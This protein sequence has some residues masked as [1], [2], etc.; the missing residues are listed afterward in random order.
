MSQILDVVEPYITGPRGPAGT[1]TSAT[2]AA[3]PPGSDPTV[4]MSGSD[5]DRAVAFGIP[6]GEKGDPGDKGDPGNGSVNS[7]NGNMGPDVVL[8]AAD[9]GGSTQATQGTMPIRGAGGRL[10]GI[11]APTASTEAANK[12][13]VDA[14]VSALSVTERES[15][16]MPD[17]RF[18]VTLD[19]GFVAGP[20]GT[21]LK[22]P[23][24][25]TPSGGET[26]HPAVVYFPDGWNGYRY[27][28]AHTPYP[29]GNDAHED[30]NICASHD[31]DTWVVPAGLVNPL[32][33]APGTPRYNS[34]TELVY[35]DGKLWCFWRYQD[36][37]A[38]AAS[39]NIY[40]R[41]STNG[42]TWTAKQLVQQSNKDTKML[43]SPTL[44]FEG[45]RWT[46]WAVDAAQP[47]NKL[48]RYR[49]TGKSPLLGQWGAEEACSLTA[50][51]GRDIW[52]IQVKRVGD[53]L[54]ALLNDC[55]AGQNGA[56]GDLYLVDSIDGLKWSAPTRQVIPR[57]K[58]GEHT[59]LYRS[60]FVPGFLDGNFGLHV[61]Y[62]GWV[63][64]SPNVWN[65]FRTFVSADSGWIPL[66]VSR[67]WQGLS[68]H[69]PR[70]R[71][72]NGMLIVEGAVSRVST[73]ADFGSLATL[74]SSL[75]RRGTKTTF[76]G[77][78]IAK[79]GA[80]IGMAEVYVA[81]DTGLVRCADYHNMDN[82]AGWIVPISFTIPADQL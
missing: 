30:P 73:T 51:S 13:Y 18:P 66:G 9:V 42:T 50:S 54:V 67:G 43:L 33:D 23:T 79:K 17:V 21:K 5:D 48:V 40:V 70:G 78:H 35:A 59:A 75:P 57:Q 45:G 24:H 31:G 27:W 39:Q 80:T 22:I 44:I 34:D 61:W 72:L 74:P 55:V 15:V 56:N 6:R 65:L 47:V 37:N 81:M 10:P 60:S 7:V 32:D 19:L 52:H 69:M 16:A 82:A 46:M 14:E 76:T 68:G 49:S 28:M 3:L 11:S 62:T 29:G 58:V 64:G 25:V 20:T 63:P 36:N 12:A 41:T 8:G 26:T 53:R 2:A 38:G 4:T 1:F 77:A 71:Y